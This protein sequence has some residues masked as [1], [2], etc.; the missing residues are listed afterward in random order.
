MA[1]DD[2]F[3][4]STGL[5]VYVERLQKHVAISSK[6]LELND[7]AMFMKLCP[8]RC[9]PIF[10]IMASRLLA[11]DKPRKQGGDRGR[12]RRAILKVLRSLRDQRDASVKKKFHVKGNRWTARG[13]RHR[14]AQRNCNV[15]SSAI[16]GWGDVTTT[17]R[18]RVPEGP[19]NRQ[20]ALWIHCTPTSLDVISRMVHKTAMPSSEAV[21]IQDSDAKLGT[22]S[23]KGVAPDLSGTPSH[24]CMSGKASLLAAFKRGAA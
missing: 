15:I 13:K 23:P 17:L 24:A 6:Y 19:K 4:F 7:G 8:S 20:K 3:R 2:E 10:T 11:G 9:R 22:V 14:A 18:F 1:A 12:I 21:D 16:S 5:T